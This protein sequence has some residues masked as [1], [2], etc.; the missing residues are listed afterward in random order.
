MYVTYPITSVRKFWIACSRD[1]TPPQ[2]AVSAVRFRVTRLEICRSTC[3]VVSCNLVIDHILE[4][5]TVRPEDGL[6]PLRGSSF[7]SLS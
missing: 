4:C 1:L 5:V 6:D 7:R 2:D 3:V